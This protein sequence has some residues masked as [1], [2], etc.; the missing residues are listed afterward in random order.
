MARHLTHVV[1]FL[2]SLADKG[3]D[4][5]DARLLHRFTTNCDEA[6]FSDIVQRHGPMVYGVCHRLLQ[7][8]HD[9]EDAFQ[10]TFLVLARRAASISKP[11][12]LGPWLY[13]VAYRTALKARGR[14]T[15]QR[16]KER[17]L[18]DVPVETTPDVIWVDLRSVLD[19]EING[20]PE[21]FRV[22]FVLCHLEGRTNEEAAR[23][24]GCPTGTILSRLATARE[25]LRVRLTRRGVTLTVGLL[26]SLVI[27]HA[28]VAVPADL[29]ALTTAAAVAGKAVGVSASVTAL[30]ER[31]LAAMDLTRIK[32]AVL[33][34]SVL[35]VMVGAAMLPYLAPS[36]TAQAEAGVL[37]D[38]PAKPMPPPEVTRGDNYLVFS[39]RT[40]LQRL[41]MTGRTGTTKAY[42]VVDSMS[43]VGAD[44]AVDAN[45]IDFE[46]LRKA[47]KPYRKAEDGI[48][49]N[50]MARADAAEKGLRVLGWALHGFL[51]QEGYRDVW[52]NSTYINGN[53]Y[54]WKSRVER[55][56]RQAAMGEPQEASVGNE[57]VKVYLVQT[58]L[59]SWL[60]GA[61]C[62]VDILTPFKAKDDGLQPKM[63][64]AIR[65]YTEQ[66]R[67]P[68]K[69]VMLIRVNAIG[70][71]GERLAERFREGGVEAFVQSLGF[72][73][74]SLNIH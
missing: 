39:V 59:S 73:N 53:D 20:L 63:R 69:D 33:V 2:R 16:M 70:E 74:Y 62:V 28:A 46:G 35:F 11:H 14:A 7:Q 48:L 54:D 24:L 27:E 50:V 57:V 52:T 38:P 29:A 8:N 36:V 34:L 65:S 37:P 32:T 67:L 41:L 9:A 61:D 21:K 12:L 30:T 43:M 5:T 22:P 66:L 44:G 45:A 6:A 26:A 51:R 17:P 56:E 47:L 64:D 72:R 1:E 60:S 55:A 10:A 49:V 18:V 25:R 40:D 42:V 4:A 71:G 23:L 13:G 3:G 58:M 31:V 15:R 68:R 19:A